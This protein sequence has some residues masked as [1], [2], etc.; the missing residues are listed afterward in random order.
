MSETDTMPVTF[1]SF[2][3]TALPVWISCPVKIS[4]T[5]NAVAI[6]LFVSRFFLRFYGI[7]IGVTP[8]R[9]TLP[10]IRQCL[11][12]ERKRK[13]LLFRLSLI[14]DLSQWTDDHGVAAVIDIV[15]VCANP[16]DTHDIRLVFDGP[17]LQQRFPGMIAPLRPVGD[18][19][20]DVVFEGGSGRR[21]GCASRVR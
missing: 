14:E 8:E 21:G 18:I 15:P 13:Y 11:F 12:F 7:K 2:T 3:K 20:E 10:D 6:S 9:E 19:K 4:R 17:G 5:M 16:V 1:P